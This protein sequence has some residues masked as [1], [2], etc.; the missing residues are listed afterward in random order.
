M[1]TLW[2][3]I[4]GALFFSFCIIGMYRA[5]KRGEQKMKTIPACNGIPE[6]IQRSVEMGRPVLFEFGSIALNLY[7]Q[8]IGPALGIL[9]EVA[10]ESARLGAH[11][12]TISFDPP[13]TAIM[14]E[15]VKNNY[16]LYGRTM[17]EMDNRYVAGTD[18]G[19]TVATLAILE[20]EKPG[21]HFLMGTTSYDAVIVCQAAADIGAFQ[22]AGAIQTF[23]LPVMSVICDYVLIGEEFAVAGS[24]FSNK[25]GQLGTIVGHDWAKAVLVGL[26][27][28]G[29][30]LAQFGLK[31][32]MS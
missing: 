21:A 19:F 18:R 1:P 13:S 27:I 3:Y 30:I 31:I 11:L 20:R 17:E 25:L 23:Q 5:E 12:I 2:E 8:Y 29:A 24:V 32:V 28:L 10:K 26:L 9:N 6:G 7:S 15:I 4:F 22:V 16:I 14:E